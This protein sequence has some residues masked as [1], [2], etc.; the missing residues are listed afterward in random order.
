M[1]KDILEDEIAFIHDANTEVCKQALLAKVRAGAVRALMGSTKKMGPVT[2]CQGR[3]IALHDV[4]SIWRPSDLA[5]HLDRIIR[6]GN[7]KPEVEVF[8]CIAE[9]TF[10]SYL[11]QLMEN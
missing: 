3:L 11:Y 2:N 4:D 6:Q 5:Q 10:G 7:T 1:E 8:R 9:G